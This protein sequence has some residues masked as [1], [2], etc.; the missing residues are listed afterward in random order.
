VTCDT[1]SANQTLGELK[2]LTLTP[3]VNPLIWESGNS[4]TFH[5]KRKWRASIKLHPVIPR[6]EKRS[7]GPSAP[8]ATPL[9]KALVTNKVSLS[10]SLSLLFWSDFSKLVYRFH[11]IFC[12]EVDVISYLAIWWCSSSVGFYGITV[13]VY[14]ERNG[15]FFFLKKKKYKLLGQWLIMVLESWFF[16]EYIVD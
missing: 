1:A 5:L 10:L 16:V 11:Y 9:T 3:N 6:S 15:F 2:T 13:F 7:S 14:W 8:S 12:V 4:N